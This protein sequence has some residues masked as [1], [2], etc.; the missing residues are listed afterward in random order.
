MI[1]DTQETQVYFGVRAGVDF[2]ALLG[3]GVFNRKRDAI[4]HAEGFQAYQVWRYVDRN[5]ERYS[6][7]IIC[8][9]DPLACVRA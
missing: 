2:S 1:A 5:G 9:R 6:E 7:E 4:L 8:E 3:R